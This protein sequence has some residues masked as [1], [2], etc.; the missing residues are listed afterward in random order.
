MSNYFSELATHLK[1]ADIGARLLLYRNSE[2]LDFLKEWLLKKNVQSE[3][4]ANTTDNTSLA[5]IIKNCKNCGITETKRY[6]WGKG[7]NG[8]MIILNQ[9]SNISA[10]EKNE[11]K[12]KSRKMLKNMMKAI[13][14]NI[15]DCYISSL[16]KCESENFMSTPG[17]MLKN[18]SPILLREIREINPKIIIIMGDSLPAKKIMNENPDKNWYN[19]DHPIAM[20]KKPELKKP[21]WATLQKLMKDVK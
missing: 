8:I 4:E 17:L 12:E 16:V 7:T 15:E 2:E 18:C 5:A 9:P 3:K 20:I 19:V 21:T 6:G 13:N 11:L 1:S 14:V 10:A